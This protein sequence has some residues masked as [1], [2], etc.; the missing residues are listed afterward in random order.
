MAL[1]KP[2]TAHPA[3][4]GGGSDSESEDEP[5][6]RGAFFFINATGWFGAG[7]GQK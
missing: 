7:I 2:P 1:K 3:D 6:V 5:P 4:E